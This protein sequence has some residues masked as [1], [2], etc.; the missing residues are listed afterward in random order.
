MLSPAFDSQVARKN[1]IG[2]NG[3]LAQTAHF[4]RLASLGELA[5]GL[6]HE[7]AQP[8]L[9]AQNYTSAAIATCKKHAEDDPALLDSLEGIHAQVSRAAQIAR[10]IQNFIAKRSPECVTFDINSAVREAAALVSHQFADRELNLTLNL[11]SDLPRA[12]ADIILIQQ[13]IVNLL[14]NAMEASTDTSHEVE[15]ETSLHSGAYLRVTVSD[16][17]PGIPVSDIETL[18]IPFCSTKSN[19]IGV[20]LS[21]S[22]TLVEAN[23]G[24][25]WAENRPSGGAMF[26]FILPVASG[27]RS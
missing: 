4:D 11:K 20:G 25:I 27:A 8:L 2:Q 18:F 23:D 15:V 7:L 10:R 3:K 21:L 13:V 6:A 19:G 5:A 24:Q 22:R 9:A 14:R 17:G 1:G 12:Y 16:H 26:S